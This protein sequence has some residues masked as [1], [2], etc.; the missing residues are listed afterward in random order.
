VLGIVL[1]A[2]VVVLMVKLGIQMVYLKVFVRHATEMVRTS[3]FVAVLFTS[4]RRLVAYTS[5]VEIYIC[6][7]KNMTARSFISCYET[8]DNRRRLSG[9]EQGQTYCFLFHTNF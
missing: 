4:W 6:V 3:L 8:T 2:L 5:V 7:E 1:S 9:F